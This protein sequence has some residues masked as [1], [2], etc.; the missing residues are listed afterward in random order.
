MSVAQVVEACKLYCLFAKLGYLFRARVCL[1][2]ALRNLNELRQSITSI[3]EAVNI[4]DKKKAECHQ[5]MEKINT[6]INNRNL[7]KLYRLE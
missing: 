1:N 4:V 3:E 5:L 6:K 2:I 7:I